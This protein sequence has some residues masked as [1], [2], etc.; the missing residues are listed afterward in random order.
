MQTVD[1]KPEPQILQIDRTRS[2][3]D[4]NV[5]RDRTHSEARRQPGAARPSK[6]QAGQVR[7]SPI[8]QALGCREVSAFE[9]GL[10]VSQR[11]SCK[12]LTKSPSRRSFKAIRQKVRTKKFNR[13]PRPLGGAASNAAR[14]SKPQAGQV[15]RLQQDLA[16]ALHWGAGPAGAEA[17]R[18]RRAEQQRQALA[19]GGGGRGREHHLQQDQ[20]GG[21]QREQEV[22]AAVAHGVGD[23]GLPGLHDAVQHGPAARPLQSQVHRD[24]GEGHGGGGRPGGREPGQ[25]AQAA[26]LGDGADPQEGHHGH[27]GQQRVDEAVEGPQRPPEAAG[28]QEVAQPVQRELERDAHDLGDEE[29]HHALGAESLHGPPRKHRGDEAE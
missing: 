16:G 28:V 21:H 20:H 22:H 19:R 12:Q 7:R 6:P 17:E 23:P 11:A 25:L 26:H 27:P 13:R 2:S 3:E 24:E 1:K 15:R 4:Q 29:E 18:A 8:D 9:G 14:P 10:D 5:Q